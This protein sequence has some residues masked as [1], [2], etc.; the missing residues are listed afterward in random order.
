MRHGRIALLTD[1]DYPWWWWMLASERFGRWIQVLL[2]GA[3]TP[4]GPCFWFPLF[5]NKFSGTME[6]FSNFTFSQKIFNFHPPKFL[7]TFFVCHRL[8]I[9][10]SLPIFTVS[11]QHFPLLLWISP[12]ISSNLRVFTFFLW[13]S[14]PPYFDHDAFMHHTMHIVDASGCWMLMWCN[15]AIFVGCAMLYRQLLYLLL[16]WTLNIII[17]IR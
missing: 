3:S 7:M 14:F 10:N 17:T 13:F 6:K 12:Q 16:I 9:L 4:R 15:L 8:Q 5:P 1:L 11:V 2:T